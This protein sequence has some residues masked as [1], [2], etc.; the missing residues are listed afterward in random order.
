MKIKV[1]IFI[2][3]YTHTVEWIMK[4]IIL[5][6]AADKKSFFTSSF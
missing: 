1:W 3:R 4:T 5:G 6:M 2:R